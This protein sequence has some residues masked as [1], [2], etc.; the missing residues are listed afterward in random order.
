VSNPFTHKV[1]RNAFLLQDVGRIE[2]DEVRLGD[3]PGLEDD[4]VDVCLLEVPAGGETRLTGANDRD[5]H[6]AFQ[7]GEVSRPPLLDQVSFGRLDLEAIFGAATDQPTH[8]FRLLGLE[9]AS[10]YRLKF[11]DR[12]AAA[13]RVLTGQV[14]MQAGVEVTLELPLSSELISIE[15][16]E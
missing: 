4:V 14:L 7:W 1:P 6:A 16:A 10:R 12:G 3:S 8:T 2:G 5:V 15:E 13:N 11:E 9:P